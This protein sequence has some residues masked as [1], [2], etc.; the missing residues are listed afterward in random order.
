LGTKREEAI[1]LNWQL[2]LTG[3]FVGIL[4][5]ATG[6]GGGSLMTPL[7]ILVFGF[8]PTVA[9]GTD[10][11]HGAL[12]KT[13]GA[14]RHRQLG[15]VQAQLSGWMLTGSAPMSLAGVAVATWLAHHYGGDLHSTSGRVLGAGLLFGGLGLVAKSLIRLRETPAGAFAMTP[16]DRVAA[17][18]IGAIGGFVV[19]L[20]SVGSGVFFALTLLIMFPLRA[21]KVVGTDIFHA[22]ALLWVAGTGH[23]VAGNVDITSVGWLLIGSIPG[24]LIGSNLTL[25]VPEPLLRLALATV[26][27]LSGL[28]LVRPSLPVFVTVLVVAAAALIAAARRHVRGVQSPPRHAPSS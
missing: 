15:T 8:K 22:A 20:T 17:V 4:V 25:R 11:V 10:I 2:S 26:L 28:Q 13:F 27:V 12:F 6:M 7:L 16:R 1:G 24:V 19:G 23:I 5:G 18:A 21:H 9:I 3:L 14:V